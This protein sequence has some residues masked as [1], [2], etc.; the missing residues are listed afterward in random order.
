MLRMRTSLAVGSRGALREGSVQEPADQRL[1]DT[2]HARGW[3]C[4]YKKGGKGLNP[5]K[6]Q[7]CLSPCADSLT[8][9]LQYALLLIFLCLGALRRACSQ[10]FLPLTGGCWG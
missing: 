6:S 2:F 8:S 1:L 4:V 3:L 5:M 9:L 10:C 7:H